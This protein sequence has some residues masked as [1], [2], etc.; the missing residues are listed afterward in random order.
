MQK[1]LLII[2]TLIAFFKSTQPARADIGIVT[3]VA[4]L[5][6]AVGYFVAVP[7]LNKDNYKEEQAAEMREV[8]E[9]SDNDD[10]LT[11]EVFIDDAIIDDAFGE[12]LSR[13]KIENFKSNLGKR[14]VD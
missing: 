14:W 8:D 9:D 11:E 6:L 10:A 12:D 7:L 2:L 4:C 1:Y 5:V 13:D 3:S